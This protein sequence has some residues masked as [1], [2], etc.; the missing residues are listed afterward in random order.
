VLPL[1]ILRRQLF[2]NA[3]TFRPSKTAGEAISGI[4]A[5]SDGE[6]IDHDAEKA[7][8]TKARRIAQELD[9]AER[10]GKLRPIAEAADAVEAALVPV[11]A[12]LDSL[13]LQIKRECPELSHQ[14]V[15]TMQRTIAKSRNALA[16]EIVETGKR[17]QDLAA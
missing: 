17:Y 7:R 1:W 14:S 5:I 13:P 12:M 2:P 16:D 3:N 15:E 4:H 8:L 11:C 10:E 6:V 9:N